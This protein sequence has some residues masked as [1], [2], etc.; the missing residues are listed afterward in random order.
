MTTVR[1]K[2]GEWSERDSGGDET[3]CTVRRRNPNYSFL[4]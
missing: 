2:N 3:R 1:K 4:I